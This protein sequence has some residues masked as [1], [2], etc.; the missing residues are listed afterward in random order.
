M[1]VNTVES[2]SFEFPIKRNTATKETN[3]IVGHFKIKC[4]KI[5]I[6]NSIY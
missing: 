6:Y 1:A 5:L 2:R 4:L 3:V